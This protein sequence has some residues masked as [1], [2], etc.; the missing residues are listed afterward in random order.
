MN[1]AEYVQLFGK[2]VPMIDTSSEDLTARPS[3]MRL[4]D[5]QDK[6]PQFFSRKLEF[7]GPKDRQREIEQL[8]RMLSLNSKTQEQASLEGDAFYGTGYGTVGRVS[9]AHNEDEVHSP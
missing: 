1:E 7:Q 3:M 9:P 6:T 8:Y 5:A 2:R 4:S